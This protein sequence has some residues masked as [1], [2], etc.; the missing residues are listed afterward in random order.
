[1]QGDY[2]FYIVV[3]YAL[4]AVVLTA[5]SVQSWRAWKKVK[6]ELGKKDA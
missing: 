1:M 2:F 5:I 4:A 6:N 3:A